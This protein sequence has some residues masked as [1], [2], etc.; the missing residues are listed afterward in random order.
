MSRWRA[1]IQNRSA[2]PEGAFYDTLGVTLA[3]YHFR[4]R[5]FTTKVLDEISLDKALMF[6]RDRYANAG[7]F[8][9]FFVGSF[10]IDKIRPY[11]EMYLASLPSLDRKESWRDVGMKRPK[12]VIHKEVYKGIEP[13]SLVRLNF[14][15]PFDWTEQNRYDLTSLIDLLNIKLQEVIREEMSGAYS[16]GASASPSKYPRQEYGISISWGCN[17]TRVDELVKAVM[18]QLDSLKLRPPAQSY[19]D[20]VKEI[21]RRHREVNLKENRFW[22][23]SLRSHY[24]DGEDPETILD[25]YKFVDKLT[26]GA[27]QSA[28][29]RYFDSNNMVEVVLFPEKK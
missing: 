15:G 17:P 22:L 4:A 18:E 8:V 14:S 20:K 11:V 9:F 6:Y 25:Y 12:G 21:Q 19:V 10:Q 26:P 1:S 5:P 27:I 2:S 16:V 3:Q 13:K 28:A 29:R 23:S 7:D 24:F